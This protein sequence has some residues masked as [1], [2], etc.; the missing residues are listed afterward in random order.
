MGYS[1]IIGNS[2]AHRDYANAYVAKLV[3]EKDRILTE[4]SNRSHGFGNLNPSSFEPFSKNPPISKVFR[5]VGLADE[6]GSGMRNTYK[7]TKLYSGA[8]PTFS[9]GDVFRIIVPLHEAATATVGPPIVPKSHDDTLHDTLDDTLDDTLELRI[10]SLIK[11]NPRINQRE[12]SQ[13]LDVSLPTIKRAMFGM[14]E[15]GVL[16]RKGGKRYGHWEIS[17]GT[18]VPVTASAKPS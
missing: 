3:I 17:G 13:Q 10:L 1:Y 18:R 15:K 7:Y 16:E 9:E 6:L 5:E 4:N 11:M 14:V 2:L 8:E 12:L